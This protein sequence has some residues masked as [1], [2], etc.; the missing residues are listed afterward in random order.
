MIN[1]VRAETEWEIARLGKFTS[2]EIDKLYTSPQA[3]VDKKAGKPSR[4]TKSYIES[5][6]AEIMTGFYRH[7]TLWQMEWGNQN[8]PFAAERLQEL[9]PNMD[10]HGK[11]NPIFLPFTDYSGGSPDGKDLTEGI[12]PEIKCPCS[13]EMHIK[14]CMLEDGLQLKKYFRKHYHQV[15][16]N[17][18]CVGKKYGIPFQDLRGLFCSYCPLV[19]TPFMDLFVLEVQP[20]IQFFESLPVVINRAE[21]LLAEVLWMMNT[22]RDQNTIAA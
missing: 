22:C 17:L 18:I 4:S 7:F 2:S 19:K 21:N 1:Y 6:A 12:V 8:E 14:Y 11:K 10:Y 9:Y 3:R 5:R 15:Q 16:M 13:P 20:D